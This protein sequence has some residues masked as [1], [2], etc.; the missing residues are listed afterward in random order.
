MNLKIAVLAGDGIGPEVILQAIKIL[1]VIGVVFNHEFV[2]EEALIGGVAIDKTGSP[3]PEE[4]LNLC[5]NTDAVLF[6]AIGDSKYDNNL[7]AKVRPEHGLLRLRKEL[8]L[9]ANIRPIKPY[10]ALLEASPLKKEIIEGTDFII[11]RELTGG[12]Y[13]SEKKLNDTG[14]VASDLCEYSEE[15]ILRITHLAFNSAQNRRKKLTFIDKANVLETSRLWRRVVKTVSKNYPDVALEFL[16]VDHAAMQIILN[17]RQF[18]VI[19]TENLFG[20]ILSDEASVITGSIGLLASAS[21]GTNNALFEPIHGPYTKAKG[22][23]SAN[24]IASI[25]S[26]AMLLEHFGLHE[27]AKKINEGVE[28]AIGYGVLTTDL[29][30]DSK[31]GTNEIGEFISNFIL[32]KDDL[33]Y[34]NSNNVTIGQSTIF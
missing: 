20:D 28:I 30:S 23:N 27:E 17:P 19:L 34:F 18:D 29:S 9:F 33:M 14:T 25:L 15:E 31:Y 11:F 13:F 6:G 24:P 32:N 16:F 10:P 12:M 7:E 1:D 26:A 5:I 2:F 8:G 22:K 21:I 3:L 4:T